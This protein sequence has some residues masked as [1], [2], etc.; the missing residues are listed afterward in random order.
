MKTKSIFSL[1]LIFIGFS[2][3]INAQ[4]YYWSDNRK[5]PLI[6]DNEAIVVKAHENS[7]TERE[8]LKESTN[9]SIERTNSKSVI[10]RSKFPQRAISNELSSKFKNSMISYKTESGEYIIPTGE[11]LFMPKKGVGFE[12]INKFADGTLEIVREN[13]NSF[14]VHVEDYSKLMDLANSLYESGLVIY[15]HPNFKIPINKDTDDDLYD[16]QYYL[17][18][19]G[20]LGGTA[21][22]DINAP[23]AW[24]VSTGVHNVRVAVIDDGVE[25]HE[26]LDGRVLPGYTA[27]SPTVGFGAPAAA[28]WHGQPC[29][30]II[31]ATQ[32][33]ID[34]IAGI[35]PCAD[36]IPVKIFNPRADAAE[37]EEAIDWAWDDGEADVLSNSWTYGT[38]STTQPGFDNI[39]LAIGRARTMGRGGL[40]SV[41]VF[42]SGNSH[43]GGGNNTQ[44][45]GVA[46]P[47]NVDGVIAVG[48]VSNQGLITNYSGRG[49]KIDLVAPS[50]TTLLQGN[51]TT[52]DREGFSGIDFGDY[53]DAFG[54]TS[55]AC[56]QVAGVAALCLSIDPRRSGNAI[57]NIL[58]SSVTDM[59]PAGFDNTFGFGRIDAKK[60]VDKA[61]NPNLLKIDGN[62]SV[63]NS[64]SLSVYD[65]NDF[66][67]GTAVTWSSTP[68]NA[69]TFSSQSN[70]TVTATRNGSYSDYAT[71]TATIQG[72]CGTWDITKL[73]YVGGVFIAPPIIGDPLYCTGPSGSFPPAANLFWLP[74]D[75][76][77]ISYTVV[78]VSPGLNM[79][80]PLN[81]P[82]P[83]G[84]VG[85][86]F[87]SSF[88]GIY[89]AIIAAN[90]SCGVNLVIANLQFVNCGSFFSYSVY[91][92]PASD[93]I[94][95]QL[96][97]DE[98]SIVST[99]N[100]ANTTS[101]PDGNYSIYDFNGIEKFKGLLNNDLT[102]IDVS[103]LKKGIYFLKIKLGQET[104]THQIII[105]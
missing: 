70:G 40:G 72:T 88:P 105:E 64:T 35:A 103:N 67:A 1:F 9:Y 55:A 68:S 37:I 11:L 81:V 82:L 65:F 7:V 90:S 99:I 49:P 39:I 50:S 104:K 12:E 60:A 30:G 54:G 76:V 53:T 52:L 91:P 46:F 4:D 22:I 18:N 85:V 87:T 17:H 28:S 51:L 10:V 31:G 32:D 29:A 69:L 97:D 78:Y 73:V 80:V 38:T 95:V 41:V 19:T 36:I 27:T 2:N 57:E 45:N 77:A 74:N 96:A 93:F 47:A 6:K 92:N 26:D 58:L 100:T 94:N 59:G 56:P 42:S 33:N 21:G 14:K 23:Q 34:G 98:S 13:Y 15:S 75:P 62:A 20:Q 5:I 101:R 48:A 24:A 86:Q 63:C 83:N 44:F 89:T 79:N 8:L 43:P 16:D 25:N 66:P 84:T 102:R 61:A 3:L 71:V